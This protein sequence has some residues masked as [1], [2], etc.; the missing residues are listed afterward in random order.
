MIWGGSSKR[1]KSL[2][3]GFT[4]ARE[5]S[6]DHFLVLAR[7]GAPPC[8]HPDPA[9]ARAAARTP[10]A[11]NR[12]ADRAAEVEATARRVRAPARARL[13]EDRAR[14]AEATPVRVRAQEPDLATELVPGGNCFS[15]LGS[16]LFTFMKREN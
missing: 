1:V 8:L 10:G 3:S 11:R 9:A 7:R 6:D 13:P 5:P 15:P 2:L 4:A 16:V 14:E 12:P